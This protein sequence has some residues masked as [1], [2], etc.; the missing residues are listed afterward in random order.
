MA[1]GFLEEAENAA[2]FEATIDIVAEGLRSAA[3]AISEILGAN[4][5][6]DLLDRIFSKFCIGK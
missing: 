3:R 6:E 4:Y 2:T 1:L 5:T